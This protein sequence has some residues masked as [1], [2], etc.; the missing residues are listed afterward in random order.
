[1]KLKIICLLSQQVSI[2][3]KYLIH[4]KMYNISYYAIL[5]ELQKLCPF[6]SAIKRNGHT[7]QTKE[8]YRKGISSAT[9]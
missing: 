9:F 5:K 3:K 2:S 6:A 8:N 7:S 4:F 1:M